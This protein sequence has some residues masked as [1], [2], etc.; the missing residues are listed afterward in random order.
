MAITN[1]LVPRFEN[2]FASQNFRNA[3]TESK[4]LT[5]ENPSDA[6]V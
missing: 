6:I 2:I 1:A 5:W 4:S 3:L